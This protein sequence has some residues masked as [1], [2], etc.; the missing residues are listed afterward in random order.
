LVAVVTVQHLILKVLL[1]VTPYLAQSHLLAV[2]V[3]LDLTLHLLA[4]TVVLVAVV[5]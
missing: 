5:V 2:V 4:Q 1:E 3:A